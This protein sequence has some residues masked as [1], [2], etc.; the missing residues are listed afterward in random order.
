MFVAL[1]S[2]QVRSGRDTA[3][4]FSRLPMLEECDAASHVLASPATAGV[5]DKSP[6]HLPSRTVPDYGRLVEIASGRSSSYTGGLG[7]STLVGGAVTA[8]RGDTSPM[9][10]PSGAAAVVAVAGIGSRGAE[11]VATAG[12]DGSGRVVRRDWSPTG[13]S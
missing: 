10:S 8:G 1:L 7:A 9:D 3:L 13:S 12:T 2:L 11:A 5:A 4:D 6:H